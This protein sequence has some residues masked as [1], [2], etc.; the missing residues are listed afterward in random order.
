VLAVINSISREPAKLNHLLPLVAKVK[1]KVIALC[2]G[3]DS[4][5]TCG[6]R[7]SSPT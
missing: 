7:A 3:E 2:I 5:P 6:A 4:W 1:G